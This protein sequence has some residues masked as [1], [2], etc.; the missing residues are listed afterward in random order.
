MRAGEAQADFDPGGRKRP[1]RPPAGPGG[2]VPRPA[3]PKPPAHEGERN[4]IPRYTA[5]VLAQPGSAFPLQRLAQLARERDGNLDNLIIEFESK[6]N[7]TSV[8]TYSAA[9][10]L[11]GLYKLDGRADQAVATFEKAIAQKPNDPAAHL[12]LARVHQDRGDTAK[13]RAS[14]EKA[15]SLQTIAADRE[16]TL[17]QLLVLSL[18][19]KDFDAAKRAHEGLV[20]LQPNNLFMKAEL[21]RELYTRSEFARSAA[22]YESVVATASGD[23]RALAPL[24]KDLGRAQAKSEQQKK[25]IATFKRA[26]AAAGPDSGIRTEVYEQLAEIYRAEQRLGELVAQLEKDNPQDATRLALLAGLYEE[27]GA[28]EKAISTYRRALLANAKLTDLRLRLVRL[29]QTSG[30][31]DEAIREYELLI[32]SS[33]NNPAFVFELCDALIQRGEQAKALMHLSQLEAH[34]GSDDDNLARLAD[35]YTK[36][37]EGDRA[38]KLLQRLASSTSGDPTYIIDLGDR[39]YDEGKRDLAVTTWKRLL[40][41]VT[42]SAKALST[43]SDVYFDHEMAAAGLEAVKEAAR[44]E[45]TSFVYQKQLAAGFERVKHYRDAERIYASLSAKAAERGDRA[46]LRDVRQRLVLVWSLQHT[47]EAQLPALAG[48]FDATPPDLEAGRMLAEAYAHLKKTNDASRILAR[49]S[50]LAPGDV[51]TWLARER[52]SVQDGKLA[53]AIDALE[54]AVK[55][56]P[57]LARDS[58]QRMA[59]YARTLGKEDAAVR[60]AAKAVELNPDDAEGHRRLGDMYRAQRDLEKAA[61]AYRTAILK[62]DRLFPVYFQLA[63]LLLTRGDTAAADRLFRRV[64]RTCPDDEMLL[65]AARASMQ[66]HLGQGTLQTVEHDLLPLTIANPRRLA[67]RKLLLEI[68]ANLTYEL[69]QRVRYGTPSERSAAERSLSTIGSRAIKPLLDALVDA[70]SGQ[71]QTAIDVLGFVNNKN[72]A[73]PLFT[74]ATGNAPLSL[75]TSAMLAVARLGSVELLSRLEPLLLGHADS[76]ANLVDAPL[77]FTEAM[78]LAVARTEGIRASQLLEKFLHHDQPTL[79][80]IGAIALGA[81]KHRAA[82]RTLIKMVSDPSEGALSRAAALSAVAALNPNEATRLSEKNLDSTNPTAYTLALGSL[83]YMS[84]RKGVSSERVANAL[85]DDL[86][87]ARTASS[88]TTRTL[89]LLALTLDSSTTTSQLLARVLFHATHEGSIER[90]IPSAVDPLL[91]VDAR[92]AALKHYEPAIERAARALLEGA[93]HSATTVLRLISDGPFGLAAAAGPLG[94]QIGNRIAMNLAPQFVG[95]IYH[96]D[97]DLQA[98]A[99]R[100]LATSNHEAAQRALSRA[101]RE[102]APNTQWIALTSTAKPDG[103]VLEAIVD[104]LRNAPGWEVRVEAARALGR[105]NSDARRD[106]AGELLEQIALHDPFALVRD[107]AL[108][109]LFVFDRARST[110]VATHLANSDPEPKVRD[111]AAKILA[112]PP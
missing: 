106:S 81:Q 70:E 87:R 55:I 91:P 8:D 46:L 5:I 65:R 32:R 110:R 57:K 43:L 31:L 23:N 51:D 52:I 64:M 36:I 15:L 77:S 97:P 56:D 4:L 105:A 21:A 17:R 10:A 98:T 40:T 79:R 24:L 2:P 107:E 99:L 25:A 49:V 14:Y 109:A 83:A 19:I 12:A 58:Y 90:A 96:P 94:M 66:I 84:D 60:Y 69:V 59:Q 53:E 47:V 1:P 33:K 95:Y 37:G 92:A 111:S 63:D 45:P 75:R 7:A 78:A 48:R 11:A 34:L 102:G 54:H 103:V 72:A 44:L 22:E 62:N 67:L 18:D 3:R 108:R 80:T 50:E 6:A 9:I 73:L 104:L 100:L 85:V 13:A 76:S 35:F 93:D 30:Q 27:T 41:V 26:L 112:T 20:K 71:Q 68:Y 29:L 42:P 28:S 82:E 101:L 89:N 61:F 39:Y 74:F 86:V 16:A 88:S 38:L